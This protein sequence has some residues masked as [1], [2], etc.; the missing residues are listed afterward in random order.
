LLGV[1]H[2]LALAKTAYVCPSVPFFATIGPD[3]DEYERL[4]VKRIYLNKTEIQNES[5]REITENVF[6]MG[7]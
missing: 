2:A 4:K 5:N 6:L 3:G 7:H 1:L